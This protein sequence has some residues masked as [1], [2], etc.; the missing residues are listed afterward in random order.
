M[1]CRFGQDFETKQKYSL[2]LHADSRL[3]EEKKTI[4]TRLTLWTEKPHIFKN[5]IK[6]RRG[7]ML[8]NYFL[9]SVSPAFFLSPKNANE[10]I[11][12]KIIIIIQCWKGYSSKKDLM[13]GGMLTE[14]DGDKD[15][16]A[17][18]VWRQFHASRHR[19]FNDGQSR[20]NGRMSTT[21]ECTWPLLSNQN[22]FFFFFLT[23]TRKNR[24]TN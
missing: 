7:G 15:E 13:V 16:L 8:L 21:S 10:P 22:W 5:S 23:K 2:F 3:V 4:E 19:C 12:K 18:D 9:F 11:E 1:H 17:L 24:I 6:K 20:L 14:D